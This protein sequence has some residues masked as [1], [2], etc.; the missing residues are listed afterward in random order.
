MRVVLD[1]NVFISA[2][3]WRGIPK[4][5]FKLAKRGKI[6]I[7]VSGE[8]VE[9]FQKVLSYPKFQDPLTI[10]KK[11]PSEIVNE[12]LEIVEY[13][14]PKKFSTIIIKDDPSDDKFLACA[15][16]CQAS[17]VVSGNKHLLKLKKFQGISIV[18]SREF[19]NI[20]KK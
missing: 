20:I 18:S 9:E 6:T 15:V 12:F 2:F 4:E 17:F 14:S 10:I 8:I 13:Y 19:L 5:I 3:L 1:T 11:T 16:S 7:C